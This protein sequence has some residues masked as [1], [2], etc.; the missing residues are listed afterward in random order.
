MQ[1]STAMHAF[2]LLM[3]HHPEVQ[4]KAQRELDAVIGYDRLPII[5]DRDSLPY[6]DNIVKELLRFSAVVPMV[7]HSNEEDDVSVCMFGTLFC[8]LAAFSRFGEDGC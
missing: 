4:E 7:P 2:F 1:S 6:I 8:L 5:E 3:V